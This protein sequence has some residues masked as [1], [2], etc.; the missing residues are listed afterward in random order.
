MD[1]YIHL[2]LK[3]GNPY[4]TAEN[5]GVLVMYGLLLG[6]IHTMR[7]LVDNT[8][9]EADGIDKLDCIIY[10]SFPSF[11][12]PD[13]VLRYCFAHI[14]KYAGRFASIHFVDLPHFKKA[15]FYTVCQTL[16]YT[17]KSIVKLTTIEE[18]HLYFG[19]IELTC[20][21][22]ENAISTQKLENIIFTF[23]GKKY[24]NGEQWGSRQWKHKIFY[25]SDSQ[26]W[27]ISKS[28][29]R[30]VGPKIP[31][32]ECKFIE[33]PHDKSTAIIEIPKT[34]WKIN[35]NFE[36][37]DS[38]KFFLNLAVSTKKVAECLN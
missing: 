11:R 16:P 26:F 17:L 19:D 36:S 13:A 10:T 30:L 6:D 24:G 23:N 18:L 35:S 28:D 8:M 14:K 38:L 21:K 27:Y 5:H 25:V 12:I 37:L 22:R 1:G 2:L 32:G 4:I 33:N 29:S 31:L 9:H 3:D 15:I 20:K 7:E 34:Q